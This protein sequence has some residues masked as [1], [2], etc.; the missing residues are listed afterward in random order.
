MTNTTSGVYWI[1]QISRDRVIYVG[2][3][4]NIEKRIRE[5][6]GKLN[7]GKHRNARLLNTWRKYGAADF[8]I[9]PLEYVAIEQMVEREQYWLD[10][11]APTCTIA[12]VTENGM[13]GLK[14]R[15]VSDE[16]RLKMSIAQTGRKMS[17]ETRLKMSMSRMGNKNSVGRTATEATRKKLSDAKKGK[18][19]SP[20]HVAKVAA[21]RR[22]HKHTD[23]QK[24]KWSEQRKGKPWSAKRRASQE[25]KG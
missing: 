20:E 18:K 17:A 15:P 11:L 10:A 12:V 3:S 9:E 24:A 7:S 6:V 13:R 8:R 4:N 21:K 16:T 23:E 25:G 1:Y 5:H 19:H 14:R 22:G 2:S